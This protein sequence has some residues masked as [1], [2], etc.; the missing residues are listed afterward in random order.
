MACSAQVV[1]VGFPSQVISVGGRMEAVT[2]ATARDP[3]VVEVERRVVAGQ[4]RV[5]LQLC[6]LG[7]GPRVVRVVAGTALDGAAGFEAGEPWRR[8]GRRPRPSGGTERMVIDQ[9]RPQ[10]HRVPGAG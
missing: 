1:R 5:V 3:V 6:L 8:I 7:D 4:A 9:R 2:A 10:Q